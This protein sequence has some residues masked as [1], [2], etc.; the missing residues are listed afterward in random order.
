MSSQPT[1]AS[2]LNGNEHPQNTS[3][4]TQL[5]PRKKAVRLRVRVPVR[6]IAW[7]VLLDK[8]LD[9]LHHPARLGSDLFAVL[10]PRIARR[11]QLE[12]RVELAR[13]FIVNELEAGAVFLA[14]SLAGIVRLRRVV[15]EEVADEIGL[16]YGFG[17]ELL[18]G[19]EV[20]PVVSAVGV[21]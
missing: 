3:S 6:T 7:R 21:H 9:P 13:V 1:L 2:L 4:L 14:R 18:E 10:R 20:V 12:R 19:G 8:V 11:T 15:E 17:T 5:T 16:D